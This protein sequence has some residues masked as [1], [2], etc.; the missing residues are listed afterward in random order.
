MERREGKL[1]MGVSCPLRFYLLEQRFKKTT[2]EITLLFPTY[3]ENYSNNKKKLYT[4]PELY[5]AIRKMITKLN[6]CIATQ[7][8][9]TLKA[10]L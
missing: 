3:N 7:K 5:L 10:M 4:F 2:R 8:L 1:K 6:L 9:A